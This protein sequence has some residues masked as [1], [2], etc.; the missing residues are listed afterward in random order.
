MK[1]NETKFQKVIEGTNQ[2][3]VPHFQRPYTWKRE[4]WDVLWDD[5]VAL[6]EDD[7]EAESPRQHFV[8]SIVTMPGLSVPEGITKYLLID[9]QQRITTLLLFLAALRDC[10]R[11]SDGKVAA[12][13]HDLYLVNRHQEGTDTYKLLPTQGDDPTESDRECFF[14][15]IDGCEHPADRQICNAYDYFRKKLQGQ[16]VEQL[17]LL[18]RIVIGRLVLVSIV[19]DRDDNPYAIF[20]S[21]NA[22]G[23]PLSQADLIRNY[24]FMRIHAERHDEVYKR[25]WRPMEMELGQEAMTEFIRH[26]L[27]REPPVVNQTDVY[28]ALKRRLDAQSGEQLIAFLDELR[29]FAHYYAC[30]LQPEREPSAAI[31]FRLKR[32]NRMEATVAY[33]F[34]LNI[35]G[36]YVGMRITEGDFAAILDAIENFLVRRYVCRAARADL[37]KM[38]PS[39]FRLARLQRD[40]VVGTRTILSRRGYPPNAEFRDTLASVELYGTGGRRE[41]AK[42]ILERIEDFLGHSERVDFASL[43]VEHVMPQTLTDWWRGHLGPEFV[44][45]HLKWLHTIGNLTLTGYNA[46]LSNSPFPDKRKLYA[47]SHV[48]LNR[49]LSQLTRWD[50]PEIE[51]RA[52]DLADRACQVWPEFG[53]ASGGNVH[54][55]EPVRGS[56]PTA[57]EILGTPHAV[58]SWQDVWRTTLGAAVTMGQLDEIC[59]SLPK[60]IS[61]RRDDL[62]APKELSP[63]AYYETNLSAERIFDACQEVAL[64]AGLSELEFHIVYASPQA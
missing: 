31:S 24:F 64:C 55:M 32:L 47:D 61:R 11:D 38:F 13:I 41:R 45:V 51:R 6:A 26:F 53:S 50:G 17:V 29:E 7:G 8:G 48:E 39:L 62:R 23:Q 12:E 9:G 34:L 59:H 14:A 49:E 58:S 21:L 19:L 56:T 43:T 33:P 60:L 20:E 25:K 52:R 35:Y 5:L 2:F 18:K 46:E 37:N 27:M 57:V 42:F 22:K 4:Q 10:V 63:G 28:F 44:D 40:L 1:A 16:T 54:E 30:L 36:E 3:L 15:I